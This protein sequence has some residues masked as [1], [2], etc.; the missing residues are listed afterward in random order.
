MEEYQKGMTIFLSSY[1]GGRT[2]QGCLCLD[3][4]KLYD[5]SYK[6]FQLYIRQGHQEFPLRAFYVQVLG[7]GF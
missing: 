7:E 6:P 1:D 4:R 3:V 5:S 2:F